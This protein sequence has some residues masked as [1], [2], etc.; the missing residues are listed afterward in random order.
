MESLNEYM[1]ETL[2]EFTLEFMDFF[3]NHGGNSQAIHAC[4][5]EWPPMEV[6]KEFPEAFLMEFLEKTSKRIFG[7]F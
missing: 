4:F 6:L 3:L 2:D 1:K 7:F 5:V